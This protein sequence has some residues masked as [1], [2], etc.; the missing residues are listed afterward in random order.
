MLPFFILG[1]ALLLGGL[2][3]MRWYAT[4]DPR[5]LMKVI[6]W[7]GGILLVLL[8]AFLGF[9][10]RLTWAFG[11][12]MGLMVWIMRFR[13]LARTAKNFSRMASGGAG[14][15]RDSSIETRFLH[16]TLN[17]RDGTLTGEILEGPHAGRA[18]S[19]LSLEEQIDLLQVCWTEDPQSAQVLETYLNR[20]RP[21]WR[22]HARA[23]GYEGGAGGGG[24]S[25]F[26]GGGSMSSEEA[27]K[28]LGL[29]EG[30]GADEIKDAHRRLMAAVH[31]DHGGTDYLASKIN[32]ARDVLLQ[33]L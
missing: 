16:M 17:H 25:E 30:A 32:Q 10:G 20:T 28:I 8:V 21:G 9:S 27:L 13:A 26:P 23:G 14:G 33:G 1:I 22:E 12:V 11:A 2:L 31:P 4:A 24:G 18:L 29:E 5:V 15:P 6:K 19:E 7:S 3:A